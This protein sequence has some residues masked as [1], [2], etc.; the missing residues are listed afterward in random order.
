MIIFS[1]T[2]TWIIEI[3][4]S[5]NIEIFKDKQFREYDKLKGR[6]NLSGQTYSILLFRSVFLGY[7]LE[8]FV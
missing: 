8:S 7:P 3:R 5:P 4:K 2:Y 6:I 1:G